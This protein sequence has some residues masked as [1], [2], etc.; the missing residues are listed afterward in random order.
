MNLTVQ[1]AFFTRLK[2]RI[3][4][5]QRVSR[6]D[7]VGGETREGNRVGGETREGA[8]KDPGEE[9]DVIEEGDEEATRTTY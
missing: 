4:V 2:I 7:R 1:D 9:E 6:E 5:E 3:A 8:H